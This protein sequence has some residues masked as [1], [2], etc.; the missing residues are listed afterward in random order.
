M[1]K[2]LS[3][4][5]ALSLAIEHYEAGR[6]HESRKV[7]EQILSVEPNSVGTL[8]LLSVIALQERRYD[9]ARDLTGKA[10]ALAPQLA[11]IHL[12]R[13]EACRHLR[14]LDEAAASFQRALD[15]QPAYPEALS[16][17]GLVLTAQRR[18]DEAFACLQKTVALK[19][20]FA[21]AHNN[22]GNLL[23]VRGQLDSA[24]VCYQRALELNPSLVWAHNNLGN[25]LKDRGQLDAALACFERALAL[26]PHFAD[27]YN[28]LAIVLK[29]RGQLDDAVARFR[30]ALA[31]SP[32][33]AD[34][35]SNLILTLRYCPG[36]EV[37]TVAVEISRWNQRHAEPLT[38]LV[39]L[40]ANDR[41]PARRLKI[42]YVSGDFRC[43]AAGLHI[44]PLFRHH[45]HELFEVFC[46][47]HGPRSDEVTAEF[48]SCADQWREVA[49][50]THVQLADLVREDQIDILVDLALHTA[51]NRLPSFAF[52]P[53]PLQ[54]SFVG[55][56]GGTGMPAIDYHLTDI[57]LE[58]PNSQNDR[59]PDA[60]FRLRSSFWCFEPPIP[61]DEV[62]PLPALTAGHVTF[63]GI[64]NFCKVNDP[65]LRIWARI[66]RA[67]HQ[68]RIIFL[69]HEGKHRQHTLDVLAAEGIGADRVEFVTPRP[70]SSYLALYHRIDLGLDTFPYNGHTSSLESYWMGVPVV[71]LIGKT[72]V[73]RAGWSQLAVLGL[74]ELAAHTPDEFVAITTRVASDLPT[75]ARLRATL[76]A[77][78]RHSPLMDAPGFARD[79]EAAYRTLWQRWCAQSG[80]DRTS[81][82]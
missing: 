62:G 58:P 2:L 72:P 32:E 65:V 34:I 50:L 79:I 81:M 64:H 4:T 25:A 68:S 77:R 27:T 73:G 23:H 29:D 15:I 30:Q 31:C 12:N 6:W 55:N 52:K 40:P 9:D 70:R 46:Y 76:R 39:R 48:R 78:L 36:H 5:D 19:P 20:D 80:S 42:G 8:H 16:N 49:S 59:G 44:L 21:E 56:P 38:K 26:D 61:S 67:V 28:H 17:L 66:L 10:L 75:L 69:T 14:R 74:D 11:A 13:G 33:R 53:A 41:T 60:P 35:H 57:Y 18:L 82:S 43:H 3:S 45:Q 63:G 54:I 47:S 24:V 1:A 7:G 51:N 71:T 22:L 37:E